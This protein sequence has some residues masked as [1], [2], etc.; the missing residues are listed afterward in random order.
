MQYEDKHASISL[1]NSISSFVVSGPDRTLAA[2]IQTLS[3]A[4]KMDSR[5]PARVPVFPE[6]AGSRHPISPDHHSLSLRPS[7][8]RPVPNRQ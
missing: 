3:A 1:A 5:P 7:R 2:L 4:T 8:R 6:E